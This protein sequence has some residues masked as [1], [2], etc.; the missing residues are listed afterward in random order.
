[1]FSRVRYPFLINM[2]SKYSDEFR[3]IKKCSKPS[4]EFEILKMSSRSSA[5]FKFIKMSLKS[6]DEFRGVAR[7]GCCNSFNY[8]S[9]P[10]GLFIVRC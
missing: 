3:I 8:E 4:D 2:I 6:L 10:F 5:Y 1:M 9:A 7:G